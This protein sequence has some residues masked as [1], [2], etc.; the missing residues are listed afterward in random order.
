M[1]Y[2][3]MK[4]WFSY[5]FHFSFVA[6]ITGSIIN[7]IIILVQ[8]TVKDG[9]SVLINTFVQSRRGNKNVKK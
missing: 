2:E 1:K 5:K 3:Y 6:N 8:F 7:R 4:Y 9:V